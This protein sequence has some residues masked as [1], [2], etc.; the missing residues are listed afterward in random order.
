[1]VLQLGAGTMTFSLARRQGGHAGW[2]PIVQARS[3][4]G[5]T[6]P[7]RRAYAVAF[8]LLIPLIVFYLSVSAASPDL[9]FVEWVNTLSPFY[10]IAVMLFV[11]YRILRAYPNSIW[12]TA[13]WF[14]FQSA[15]FFGFGPLVEVYGNFETR[16]ALQVS[17]FAT[18]PEELLRANMLSTIGIFS[19]LFG[20]FLHTVMRANRWAGSHAAGSSVTSPTVRPEAVAV[21]FVI[22]GAVLMYG[23]VNPA[24]WGM[25]DIVIPGFLVS[26]SSLIDV[27]FAVMAFL[28]ASGNARMRRLFWLLWPIHLFLSLLGFSKTDILRAILLPALGAYIGHKRLWRFGV[29]LAGMVVALMLSQPFVTYGRAIVQEETGTINEAG[30]LRRLEITKN[31]IL[32]PREVDPA[33]VEQGW[34]MRLDY[35]GVQAFA[36][37]FYD[38]GERV[39]TLT[40]IWIHFV[41]RFIWPE[42]PI[43]ENP[44][45]LV[46]TLATGNIDLG[47]TGISFYADAYWQFGWWG[48][49]ISCLLLGLLFATMTIQ[50]LRVI[51]TR[52]F[53]LIPTVLIAIQTALGIPT[54]FLI[55]IFGVLPVYYA[56]LLGVRT[57]AHM[58]QSS[59]RKPS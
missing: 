37:N 57:F 9:E 13:I 25:I 49:V 6:N 58:L 54:E 5:F 16:R 42:K 17:P 55:S 48:V 21:V 34:W 36:M 43:V 31:Y 19:V 52:D 39:D 18:T 2:P 28:A 24:K 11:V 59:K 51:S 56:Y 41:P 29:W 14:P 3:S 50:S 12:T 47:F 15:I 26:V 40:N 1:M 20:F 44:G 10:L 22:A 38:R 53:I 45:Q 7:V 27:G 46:S 23:F 35:A 8:V 32:E 4:G 33:A 30:Y